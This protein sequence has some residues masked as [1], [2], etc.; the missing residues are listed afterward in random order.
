LQH[1]ALSACKG[2]HTLFTGQRERR[3]E[4][5][6]ERKKEREGGRERKREREREKERERER[7]RKREKRENERER[8]RERENERERERERGFIFKGMICSLAPYSYLVMEYFRTITDIHSHKT[9]S[10][11]IMQSSP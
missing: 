4:R 6:R 5:Q 1:I 2:E 7:E 3:G 9:F 11:L 8:E 10:T